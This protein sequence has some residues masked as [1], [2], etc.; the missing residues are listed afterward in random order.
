[1]GL[2]LSILAIAAIVGVYHIAD[3]LEEIAS[4]I[5]AVSDDTE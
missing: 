3:A 5:R 1:M 4:A 2:W